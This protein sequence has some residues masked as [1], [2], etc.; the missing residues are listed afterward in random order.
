MKKAW[1]KQLH[2]QI[3][4]GLILGLVWGLIASLTGFSEFTTDYIQPVGT[5]FIN[6]LKLIAVPL[7]LASLVVGVT[8][9]NDT[10][11]LSRMGGKTVGIYIVTTIFAI[12]IGLTVVNVLQPGDFLP[13]KPRPN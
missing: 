12:T 1:Y 7:V 4:T 2:W 8:S 5:I 13:A 3:I 6:L 11:K 9:L 10:T